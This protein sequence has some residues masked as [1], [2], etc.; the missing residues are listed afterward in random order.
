MTSHSFGRVNG[1]I[2]FVDG[3]H[4]CRASA[5]NGGIMLCQTPHRIERDDFAR[6]AAHNGRRVCAERFE[7]G[8]TGFADARG[9]RIKYP[10]LAVLVQFVGD[11]R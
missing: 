2:D 4:A 3:F 10:R 7:N 8:G 1:G 5:G 9:D 6:I 11:F